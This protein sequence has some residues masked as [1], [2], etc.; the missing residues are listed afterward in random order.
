MEIF[1]L[2][3]GFGPR[4]GLTYRSA[5]YYATP[6]D[7]LTHLLCQ[8]NNRK[9]AWAR[10]TVGEIVTRIDFSKRSGFR[11]YA[12]WRHAVQPLAFWAK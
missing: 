8:Q 9:T 1:A 6:G 3:E 12:G 10:A 11:P 7:L 2:V 5:G 4:G